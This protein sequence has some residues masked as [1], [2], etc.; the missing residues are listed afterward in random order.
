MD[1]IIIEKQTALGLYTGDKLDPF[2]ADIEK[3]V[4]SIVPDVSTAQ[5]R[6]N[7]ASLAHDVARSKTTFDGFGKE[8]VAD[9]K[10]KA[11]KVDSARKKARDFLDDL[12][13][14][15]RQPLT[16][17]EDAEK[18]RIEAE[19]TAR[20]LEIAHT[21]ALAEDD[22]FNRMKEVKRKEAEFA[23]IEQDKK[24][25]ALADA[26]LKERI[27]REK[28]LKKE[29]AA[30]AKKEADEKANL[31]KERAAKKLAEEK[32]RAEKAEKDRLQAIEDARVAK[33]KAAEKAA[34]EKEIAVKEAQRKAKEEA[35][36]KERDRLAKEKAEREAA[37]KK[38]ANK[39]HRA[40]VKKEA[41]YF[42]KG[43]YGTSEEQANGIF[44]A[45]S[46]GGVPH[47]SVNY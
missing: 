14:R 13:A 27:E 16:D 47:I 32:A 6:K 7:I 44:D 42:I 15:A 23:K 5:G 36:Q 43:I 45:I 3:K 22:L 11:K 12:K 25:Q 18:F 19:E 21:E 29:A 35:E 46:S 24:E 33:E 26:L 17:W 39:A 37:E 38:A 1:L 8:L 30:K 41:V 2:L 10:S 31:A 20:E 9:W 40:K 4:M 28:R 34:Q